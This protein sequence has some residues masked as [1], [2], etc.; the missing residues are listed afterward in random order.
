MDGVLLCARALSL[1]RFGLEGVSGT[2][3]ITYHLFSG[4]GTPCLVH[5]R[6]PSI[7]NRYLAFRGIV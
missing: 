5:F 6:Q 1:V 2:I 7:A 3:N 4:V